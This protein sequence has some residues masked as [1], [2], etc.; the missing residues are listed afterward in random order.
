MDD[1]AQGLLRVC[2]MRHAHTDS[3]SLSLES[4]FT[5]LPQK[6]DVAQTKLNSPIRHSKSRRSQ[7][8]GT[9]VHHKAALALEKTTVALGMNESTV[10]RFHDTE[11]AINNAFV[12]NVRYKPVVG[13]NRRCADQGEGMSTRDDDLGLMVKKTTTLNQKPCVHCFALEKKKK[14]KK[15]KQ[16]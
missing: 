16:P 1:I 5:E 6:R 11:V 13:Q 14:K 4:Y 3:L 15:K 9:V 12:L 10:K 8:R 7:R 2:S